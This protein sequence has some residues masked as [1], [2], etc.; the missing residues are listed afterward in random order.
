MLTKTLEKEE[1]VKQTTTWN[2]NG[3]Q[4]QERDTLGLNDIVGK[5][6]QAGPP[7]KGEEK[8]DVKITLYANGFCIDEGDF[9]DYNEPQNKEFMEDVKKG[10]VPKEL[11]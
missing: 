6:K 9:R 10:I 11:Q 4:A 7:K 3:V 8:S 2:G 1:E 5:A